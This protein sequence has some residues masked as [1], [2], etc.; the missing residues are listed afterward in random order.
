MSPWRKIH[1]DSFLLIDA[2][3]SRSTSDHNW[4]NN[5]SNQNIKSPMSTTTRLKTLQS[6][7]IG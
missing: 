7:K 1:L 5:R 2:R 4:N 6:S 3:T